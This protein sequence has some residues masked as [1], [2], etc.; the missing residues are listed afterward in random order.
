[1]CVSG[2]VVKRAQEV[3]KRTPGDD[4]SRNPLLAGSVGIVGYV[5]PRG[6][7]LQEAAAVQEQKNVVSPPLKL[8]DNR[9]SVPRMAQVCVRPLPKSKLYSCK[10]CT[11]GV[12]APSAFH[13]ESPMLCRQLNKSCP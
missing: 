8:R 11:V 10:K 9:R 5:V 2:T 7:I 1:M 4:S 6:A 13:L 3:R 12:A